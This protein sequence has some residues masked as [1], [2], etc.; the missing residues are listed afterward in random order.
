MKKIH[1]MT[2]GLLAVLAIETAAN[3]L[4]TGQ[5]I[6][7]SLESVPMSKVLR[8]I[9]DQNG[10]NLVMSD[11]IEGAI[12]VQLEN[13]DLQTALDAI[14]TANG[15]SYSVRENIV[16]IKA[17]E[18]TDSGELTSRTVLLKYL[19]PVTAKKALESRKSQKGQIII[20]DNNGGE[21]TPATSY[22][23]NRI[24]ITDYPFIV[25]QLVQLV[26]DMDVPERVILIE[27]KIL[28]TKVDNKSKLGF[29]WP[30]SAS[31]KLT[32]VSDGTTTSSSSSTTTTTKNSSGAYQPQNGSWTWGTLS[33]G[34]LS[35]AL[36]FLE[37]NGNSKL[38]SDPRITTLEN[39]EAEIS[40][41]TV[42]P[43]Q[44][45]NRFT[46]GA[47]TQDIVTFQDIDVGISLK[48]TPRINEDGRITLDVQP[49]VEDI[50]GY[51][52]T[53]GNQK[54]IT[55][56]RSIKTRITVNDGETAALG[57]LLKEDEIKTVQRVPLLG[58]I[59]LLGSLLFTN[60]AKEK[61]TTDLIIF[62]TPHIL[63]AGD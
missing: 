9:A 61:S 43:I 34:E 33:V 31:T 6:S 59:P 17:Q 11:Q 48:V 2:L 18:S 45:I 63:P 49:K 21:G 51:V 53:G 14:L 29:L 36:D 5:K 38:L 15:Y 42:I 28:E 55:S 44:T 24:L 41:A 30:S 16:V 25:D 56:S 4:Q 46:E 50:I 58:H 26:S 32:G 54:P 13:V 23:A 57:G 8:M 12:S 47:A 1:L 52:G 62:I 3:P 10:L 40:I 19:D 35:A 60:Q 20:L 27:A 37:Q 39:N 22:R 7:L